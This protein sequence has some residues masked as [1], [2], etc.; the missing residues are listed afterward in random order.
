V[1][2]AQAA[3]QPGHI[4]VLSD[5]IDQPALMY[6]FLTREDPRVYRELG[7]GG[8]G[9]VVGHLQDERYLRG[10]VVIAKPD[11]KVSQAREIYTASLQGQDD[12]GKPTNTV[13]YRVWV[14]D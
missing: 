1:D 5:Q 8:A 9:A 7:V 13:V 10:T 6:A 4:V 11:E 3:R 12:W 14:V 2:A